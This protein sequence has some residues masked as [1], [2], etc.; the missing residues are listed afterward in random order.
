MLEPVGLNRHPLLALEPVDFSMPKAP[1]PA[2]NGLVVAADTTP[3]LASVRRPVAP[4]FC[5]LIEVGFAEAVGLLAY[6]QLAILAVG[7][8][9]SLVEVLDEEFAHDETIAKK[10]W[11][12][13]KESNP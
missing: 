12:R 13:M 5:S 4:T 2:V 11:L 7:A 10:I 8:T 9:S 1:Q 6:T 3:L